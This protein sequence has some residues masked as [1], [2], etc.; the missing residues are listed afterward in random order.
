M[1]TLDQAFFLDYF[2]S[3]PEK[4]EEVLLAANTAAELVGGEDEIRVVDEKTADEEVHK[5]TAETADSFSKPPTSAS[6]STLES[7][8]AH[9]SHPNAPTASAFCASSSSAKASSLPSAGSMESHGGHFDHHHHQQQ[10]QR[11]SLLRRQMALLQSHRALLE[12]QYRIEM[13]NGQIYQGGNGPTTFTGSNTIPSLD[14]LGTTGTIGMNGLSTR[15][16]TSRNTTGDEESGPG[17]D[18]MAVET[19]AGSNAD[20]EITSTSNDDDDVA[21]PSTST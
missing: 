2:R 15:T 8:G 3:N 17:T 4:V 7:S 18:G 16:S 6:A 12:E 19:G 11:L 10:Q 9:L 13:Q 14:V 5:N 1:P 21:S 20:A